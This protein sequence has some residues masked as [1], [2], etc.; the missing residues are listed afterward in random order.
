M[1]F[2]VAGRWSHN[3][4][5]YVRST[6]VPNVLS[7]KISEPSQR[8]A[9]RQIKTNPRTLQKLP[10]PQ[11]HKS[12]SDI[13]LE[14]VNCNLYSFQVI[15]CLVCMEKIQLGSPKFYCYL[16]KNG[17]L[18]FQIY[19]KEFYKKRHPSVP[20]INSPQEIPRQDKFTYFYKTF[21]AHWAVN[22]HCSR[23]KSPRFFL[24]NC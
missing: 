20:K 4:V 23:H 18:L 11:S 7:S 13:G 22:S 16:N 2:Q 6:H 10:F 21:H 3:V 9:K 5:A 24:T 14:A 8:N 17:A 15:S 12:V 19:L 1:I